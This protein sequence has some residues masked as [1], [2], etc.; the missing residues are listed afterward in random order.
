MRGLIQ[1]EIEGPRVCYCANPDRLARLADL[2]RRVDRRGLRA[3]RGAAMT[4]ESPPRPAQDAGHDAVVAK[5]STLDRFLPLWIAL[6]MVAGVGLGSLI[7]QLNDWLDEL[8][9][10]T[11][12][13]PIAIGLLL[14]MYPVLAKVRYEELGRLRAR[15][16][17]CS[18]PR[19]GSTGCSA[20]C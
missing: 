9:I 17:R 20:R 4:V 1:G 18:S 2:A 11:V 12:S 14:M 13:L 6:A 7:P 10:G 16:G 3:D 5:L 8:R 15:A 19:S